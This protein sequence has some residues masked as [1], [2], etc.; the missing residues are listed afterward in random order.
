MQQNTH[1]FGG[2]HAQQHGK[3]VLRHGRQLVLLNVLGKHD[4]R[5]NRALDGVDVGAAHEAHQ[6]VEQRWPLLGV[7]VARNLTD[8]HGLPM[9]W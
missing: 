3:E 7:V 6:R 4:Q 9:D 2:E 1:I 5:A 8:R